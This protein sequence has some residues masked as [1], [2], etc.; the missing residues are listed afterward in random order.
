MVPIFVFDFGGGIAQT[1]KDV[2]LDF[3]SKDF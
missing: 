2:I 1:N 3:L